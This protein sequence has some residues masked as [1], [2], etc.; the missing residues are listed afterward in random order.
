MHRHRLLTLAL[1]T[2][3]LSATIA[4]ADDKKP[5]KP[6]RALL[7]TGGC[8]HDYAKQKQIL[9]EFVSKRA[10]VEWTV[11][12][13]GGSS[14]SSMIPF[15]EKDDWAKGYDVVV[16]NE[17]FSDA[18]DPAWTAKILK[19]HREGTPAVVIH[20]AMH[21]YRDKTDE[22]FK[23]LGVTSRGHGANYPF[24]VV[25]VEPKDPIMKDFGEKWNTPKGELYLIEKLWPTARPLAHAMSRDTKKNEV[26]IWTNN[27]G[28]HT[29][30]FGTTI[31]HHNEEMNDEVFQNYV[32][33]GLLWSC[34]KLNDDYLQPA[35]ELKIDF[36]GEPKDDK[37]KGPQGE[38]TPAKPNK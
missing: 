36:I 30:V 17:C 38:P 31:G 19:P 29:R 10:N 26:C 6:I 13:Q 35:A 7:I 28:D 23:F 8:C 20:C 18:A 1:L 34:D 32:T 37:P 3:T 21:C 27:Y 4:A 2:I 15:Y 33:R 22:W 12:H 9:P 11:V 14:T 16:H 5:I 25:S 24:E